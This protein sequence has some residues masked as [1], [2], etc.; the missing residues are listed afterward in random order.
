MCAD[1]CH[2]NVFKLYYGDYSIQVH[3]NPQCNQDDTMTDE[4]VKVTK[5]SALNGFGFVRG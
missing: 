5:A 2:A 3:A 4:Y 1:T